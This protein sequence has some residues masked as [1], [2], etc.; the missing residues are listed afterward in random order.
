M[1]QA[2][3]AS[4]GSTRSVSSRG[5]G[6]TGS[7]GISMPQIHVVQT[8]ASQLAGGVT[9]SETYS[10]MNVSGPRKNTVPGYPDACPHCDWVWVGPGSGD[11]VC[12]VCGEE[13]KD[14][15]GYCECGEGCHCDVPVGDD[16]TVRIFLIVLAGAYAI[17][18]VRTRQETIEAV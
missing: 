10:R 9:S 4:M 7:T 2:P 18:R 11:Y 1:A 13:L 15:E 8:S 17:Y 6:S 5:I 12:S 3:V 14:C 16:W